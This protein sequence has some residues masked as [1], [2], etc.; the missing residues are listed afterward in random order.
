VQSGTTL[1]EVFAQDKLK[2]DFEGADLQFIH[3]RVGVTDLYFVSHQ[4]N[5]PLDASCIFR[6]TGKRPELW[7]PETGAIRELPE[8]TEQDGRI[9]IPLHFEPMQSWFVVFKESNQKSEART[10]NGAKNFPELKSVQELAGPWQVV[11]DPKWGGPKEAVTFAKLTDWSKHPDPRIHYYSG[12]ATYRTSFQFKIE[13]SKLKIF[14]DL[15][16]VEVMARVRLNGK[17]CG[18]AWKPPYRVDITDAVRAGANELEIDG[19]NLWINRM[20][21]DEQLPLDSNWKDFETLLEWPDWFKAG[22][23]RPSGRYTFTSCRHYQK[24]S[25]LVPS[26]LLGPVTMQ[27]IETPTP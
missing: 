22:N 4:E 8:F 3:R 9:I 2:P 27:V 12:T 19:V 25:P 20:I 6:V 17:D 23:P 11:F 5:R 7:N 24:D 15:G 18:I 13:N 21:G 26:G 10:Q 14:L 1:A 16:A